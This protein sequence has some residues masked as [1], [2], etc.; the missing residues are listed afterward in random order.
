MIDKE[1]AYKMA[2]EYINTYHKIRGDTLVILDDRT[3]EEEVG[4][5]FFYQTKR[6]LETNMTR[7]KMVG[8]Y[9]II[10]DRWDGSIHYLDVENGID[11]AISLYKENRGK[12][13]ENYSDLD[14]FLECYIA[15]NAIGEFSSDEA[16]IQYYI[17]YA[18]SREVQE[19]IEQGKCLLK[20][21]H[22]SGERINELTDRSF[23]NSET[24]RQWLIKI[25]S[26]LESAK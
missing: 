14:G 2:T 25:I 9:P 18:Q 10:V 26:L 5:I 7:Y 22:F 17:T 13:L 20:K 6:G 15:Q 21:E 4:W 8:N 19:V 12:V 23:E 24:A 3:I 1:I 11:T 16:A